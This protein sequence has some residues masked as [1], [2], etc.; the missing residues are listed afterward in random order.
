[1]SRTE[2]PDF[3]EHASLEARCDAVLLGRLGNELARLYRDT[4]QAPL[5]PRLQALIDRLDGAIGQRTGG[6]GPGEGFAA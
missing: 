6:S 4:L 3:S 1:M 5:P 2:L